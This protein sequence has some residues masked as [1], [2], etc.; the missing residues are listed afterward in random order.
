M[1]LFAAFCGV[2]AANCEA[3]LA[4]VNAAAEEGLFPDVV[5]GVDRTSATIL[6]FS[7]AIVSDAHADD[8]ELPTDPRDFE[9]GSATTGTIDAA[10]LPSVLV[11]L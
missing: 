4:P 9:L 11:G 1:R 2:V 10:S 6:E 5:L 8:A 3:L 7:S